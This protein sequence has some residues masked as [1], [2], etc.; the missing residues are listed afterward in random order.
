MYYLLRRKGFITGYTKLKY[1]FRNYHNEKN[2][3]ISKCVTIK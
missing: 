3:K 2:L 1:Y